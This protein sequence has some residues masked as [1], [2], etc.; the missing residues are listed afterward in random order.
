M[1]PKDSDLS[2]NKEELEEEGGEGTHA[3][4]RNPGI[5]PAVE[6]MAIAPPWFVERALKPISEEVSS[7][8]L[9]PVY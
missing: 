4:G 8:L 9:L 3:K 6:V 7:I 1:P 5:V 2:T